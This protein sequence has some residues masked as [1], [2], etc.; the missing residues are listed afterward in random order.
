ME[1]NIKLV[2][3]N[4][5]RPA[6][7]GQLFDAPLVNMNYHSDHFVGTTSSRGEFLYFPDETITFTLGNHHFSTLKAAPHLSI[8]DFFEEPDLSNSVTNLHRLLQSICQIT[9]K[10]TMKLPDLMEFDLA[11]LDFSQSPVL[12]SNDPR[13]QKLLAVHGNQ[14]NPLQLVPAEIV[15]DQLHISPAMQKESSKDPSHNSVVQITAL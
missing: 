5:P 2:E 11:A 13:V 4:D 3:E 1:E 7:I 14:T 9:A 15:L 10:N 8:N 12:F 6:V